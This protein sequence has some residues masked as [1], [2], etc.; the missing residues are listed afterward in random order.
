MSIFTTFTLTSNVGNVT[1]LLCTN[2]IEGITTI[3]IT[4]VKFK[5]KLKFAKSL[6]L[7]MNRV[8]DWLYR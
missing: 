3:K 7:I 6:T 8:N 4:A 2:K 1:F 5:D